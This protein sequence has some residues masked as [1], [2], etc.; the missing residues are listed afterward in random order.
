MFTINF[1]FDGTLYVW[2][3]SKSLEDVGK[4][5]YPMEQEHIWP[6]L[7]AAERLNIFK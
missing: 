7:Y 6:M 5:N 2:D 4:T 3:S 1:D